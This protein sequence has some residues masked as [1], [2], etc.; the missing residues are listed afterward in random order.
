MDYRLQYRK[1][2]AWI[3]LVP[4]VN[5]A[6]RYRD[7]A[8]GKRG[9]IVEEREFE[10]THRFA[11]V[12]VDWIRLFVTRSSDEGRR[13]PAGERVVVPEAK[14]K[15]ILRRIEVFEAES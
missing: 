14:R 4:P 12:V 11:P 9:Y 3:D 13:E 8:E 1:D 6:I 2:N 7:F 5:N 10:E 15:T